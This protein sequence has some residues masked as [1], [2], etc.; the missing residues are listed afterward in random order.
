MLFT[1]SFVLEALVYDMNS[2]CTS[3]LVD[4]EGDQ[5]SEED[6]EKE[7]KKEKEGQILFDYHFLVSEIT[8]ITYLGHVVQSAP[9]ATFQEVLSPPPDLG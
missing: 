3:E 8:L 1:S 6:S 5:D 4:F 7:N 2:L 9:D